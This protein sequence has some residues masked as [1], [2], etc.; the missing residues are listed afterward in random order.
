[1]MHVILQHFIRNI[2]SLGIMSE[3]HAS[4][5]RHNTSFVCYIL[6]S[7]HFMIGEIEKSIL[8]K[9]LHKSRKTQRISHDLNQ[10]VTN[11]SLQCY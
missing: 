10:N 7:L 4:L 1:M 2:H 3:F 6:N 5:H 9:S 8:L 11:R